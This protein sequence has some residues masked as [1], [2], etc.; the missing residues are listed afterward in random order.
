MGID[1]IDP[2]AWARHIVGGAVDGGLNRDDL[3][4][5]R[6]IAGYKLPALRRQS[7]GLAGE[8]AVRQTVMEMFPGGRATLV[9]VVRRGGVVPVVDLL[10][11]V[12]GGLI[13]IEAKANDAA[14]GVSNQTGLVDG[15]RAHTPGGRKTVLQLSP[16]W[17]DLRLH[18]LRTYHG[19]DGIALAKKIYDAWTK[20]KLRVLFARAPDIRDGLTHVKFEDVTDEFIAYKNVPVN[21]APHVPGVTAPH[22]PTTP[23]APVVPAPGP[24]ATPTNYWDQPGRLLTQAP[25]DADRGL[26]PKPG[27]GPAGSGG[28]SA[29]IG[30][31]AGSG[32]SGAGGAPDGGGPSTRGGA[33]GASA[34]AVADAPS[35]SPP[36]PPPPQAP[37]R[38][39]A[40]AASEAGEAASGGLRGLARKLNPKLIGV[41][42]WRAVRAVTKFAVLS[43]LQMGRFDF[44]FAVAVAWLEQIFTWKARAEKPERDK[45]RAIEAALKQSPTIEKLLSANI[46]SNA[47]VLDALVAEWDAGNGTGFLYARL[48]AEVEVEM[49]FNIRDEEVEP[50]S[51]YRPVTKIQ[52]TPTSTEFGTELT[53]ISRTYVNVTSEDTVRNFEAG[54]GV[55]YFR[56]AVVKKRLRYTF[57]PPVVTPFDIV[58]S[59]LNNLF[60]DAIYFIGSF[61]GS[62]VF[63]SF[64]G[65]DYRYSYK[66]QFTVWF[67]GFPAALKPGA[68]E[69]LLAYL[70]WAAKIL[71][72]HPLEQV[73][74]YG[75]FQDPMRGLQKRLVL[76]QSVH[77]GQP[78]DNRNFSA[79][80]RYIRDMDPTD[81][82]A[83]VVAAQEALR[84]GA[85]HILFNLG[86]LE[87]AIRAQKVEYFYMGPN[88]SPPKR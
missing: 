46:L 14:V 73:D 6:R 16:E 49:F 31:R 40:S 20:G 29:G 87:R 74:M 64:T 35:P 45:Q 47:Q 37:L 23:H 30:G 51:I 55:G 7:S 22:A 15:K 13:L 53:E 43:F 57:I 67:D 9:D 68:C 3:D 11:E 75:R 50:I 26:A 27:K 66:E 24:P 34:P 5:A 83:E 81:K 71:S 19:D 4:D 85:D 72:K 77:D 2:R 1:N 79:V 12:D 56:K 38:G 17:L 52:I 84:E 86:R 58:V 60:L 36:P 39:G 32:G 48:E 78:P 10:F 25:S 80:K 18:E 44:F 33:S 70:H 76:L 69:N 8:S 62:G 88:W 59:K 21:R 63:D 28:G 41:G 61:T 54:A 65:F 42:A 82:S